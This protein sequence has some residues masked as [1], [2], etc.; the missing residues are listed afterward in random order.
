[1]SWSPAFLDAIANRARA[2][3]YLLEVVEMGRAPGTAYSVGSHK[4]LGT[5]T[6]VGARGV[7]VQGATLSPRG[8]TSTIGAFYIGIVGDIRELLQHVTRGTVVQLKA[9]FD[10][11]LPS[12]FQPI[13]V[14]QVRNLRGRAPMWTLETHDLATAVRQRMDTSTAL[15]ELFAGIGSV[16]EV[17]FAYTPADTELNVTTFTGFGKQTGGKGA[18]LVTPVTGDPFYLTYTGTATSPNRLTGVSAAGVYGSTAVYAA[19][20][21]DVTEVAWLDGHPLDIVRRILTS[22][23]GTNGAY[24]VYPGGWGLGIDSAMIDNEDIDRWEADAMVVAS[25]TYEWNLIQAALVDDSLAWMSAFLSPAGMFLSSRQGRLTVRAAQDTQT[26]PY[27]S[28]IS[29]TDADVSAVLD[30]EAWDYT[31]FPEH[32]TMYVRSTPLSMLTV[33]AGGVTYATLPGGT[34]V[35]YD[36]SDRLFANGVAVSDEMFARMKESLVRVPERI[37]FQAAGLRLSQLAPG[38]VVDFT[39]KRTHSRRDGAAGWNERRALVAEVSPDWDGGTV[40]IALFIYPE[41]EDAFV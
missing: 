23:D 4:G 5:S 26:A 9:G 39:S 11:M 24:D 34:G 8:W 25:G 7:K 27:H 36:L 17:S 10:G 3:R 18:V 29:I 12:Q 38:D 14:G 13:A 40:R 1:M 21:S 32:S 20:T 2:P 37:A 28:G 31:H 19:P 22:R 6:V 41:S 30:Y 15:S 16:A 35:E 33:S